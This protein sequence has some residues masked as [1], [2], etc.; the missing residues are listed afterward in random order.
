ML[1]LSM[2]D[3]YFCE[4]YS[5]SCYY[6]AFHLDQNIFNCPLINLIFIWSP[7][8]DIRKDFNTF[9]DTTSDGWKTQMEM[10]LEMIFSPNPLFCFT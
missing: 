5:Y 2:E 4:L 1:K 7:N 8:R 10:C 6:S 3:K 9:K